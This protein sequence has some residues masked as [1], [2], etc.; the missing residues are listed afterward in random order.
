MAS[1]DGRNPCDLLSLDVSG[2]QGDDVAGPVTTFRPA[3]VLL[4]GNRCK[5]HLQVQGMQPEQQVANHRRRL[6]GVRYLNQDAPG[7]VV[8]DYRLANV[9]DPDIVLAHDSGNFRGQAG[10][11]PAGDIN[12]YQL[13]HSRCSPL[14]VPV[15][16]KE[17]HQCR[18]RAAS[19]GAV[20]AHAGHARPG[21]AQ[22]R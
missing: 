6:G 18:Q 22:G 9:E 21:N 19:P 5:P 20:C 3:L 4:D 10:L 14:P 16:Q 13:T 8:M 2:Q 17:S 1:C 12:Q 7:Q 15:R 11:V